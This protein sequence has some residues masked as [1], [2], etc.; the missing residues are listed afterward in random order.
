MIGVEG[1]EHIASFILQSE[2]IE[3]VILSNNII[4]DEG[5]LAMGKVREL[6]VFLF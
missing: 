4:A 2:C 5:A 3:E 6:L 1:A